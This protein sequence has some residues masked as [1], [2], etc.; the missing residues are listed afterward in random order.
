MVMSDSSRNRVLCIEDSHDECELVREIL[1]G[2]EVVCADTIAS[3]KSMLSAGQFSLVII[4]E[5][6]PDG[7]G[8]EMCRRIRRKHPGLPVIMISGDS[9]ITTVEAS[10]AGARDFL[11]K[12]KVSFVDDLYRA[13]V[14]TVRSAAA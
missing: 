8:M 7:S 1:K 3:A 6:L 12:S 10:A 4:D 2:Y 9:N 13:A 14:N 5:H 11:S